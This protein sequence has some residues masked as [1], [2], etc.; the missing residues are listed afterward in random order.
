VIITEANPLPMPKRAQRP[1]T[2][3]AVAFDLDGT[4]VN[5]L[6]AIHA[7][8]N[9]V[10]APIIGRSIPEDEVVSRL[11]PRAVEIMRIYDPENAETLIHTYLDYY[12]SVHLSHSRLYPGISELVQ[13]LAQ[14]GCKLGVVTSKR[15]KTAIPTLEHFGLLKHFS[16]IVTEDD[17]S[18]LKPDP[19]PI[20]MTAAGLGVDPGEVLVVGDNPTDMLGARAAGAFGGAATWGYYSGKVIELAD[21]VFERPSDVLAVCAE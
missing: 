17:V 11:G 2:F 13:E 8:F 3:R 1:E 12:L 19:E 10:L 6:P 4:L 21:L 16:V 18:S 15:H 14:R 20:L 9:G 5:T 7:A